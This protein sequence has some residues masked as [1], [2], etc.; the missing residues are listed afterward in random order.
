MEGEQPY[1]GDLLTMV[2][3]HLHPT[4]M[5]LQVFPSAVDK[6]NVVEIDSMHSQ[7]GAHRATFFCSLDLHFTGQI[8]ATSAEVTL[9]C[10]LVRESLSKSP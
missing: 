8:I 9:N 1:L 7:I 10:G 3:N 4:G 6:S 2:I 5:I